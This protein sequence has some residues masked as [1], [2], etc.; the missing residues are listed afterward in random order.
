MSKEIQISFSFAGT[1]WD[2][3]IVEMHGIMTGEDINRMEQMVK[4]DLDFYFDKGKGEYT[5]KGKWEIMHP[6]DGESYWDLE[7]IAFKPMPI[8]ECDDQ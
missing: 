1:W 8:D 5:F 3:F 4:E 2:P 6:D 7:Q